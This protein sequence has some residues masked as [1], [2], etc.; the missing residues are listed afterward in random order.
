MKLAG[1][2]PIE[3]LDDERL[4]N[5]ERHV[6]AGAA[7]RLAR[8][9]PP[10][11]SLALAATVMFATGVAGVV[12][13]RLHGAPAI[14]TAPVASDPATFAVAIDGARPRVDIGDA[15]IAGEPGAVFQVTR[16]AGGVLIAMTRGKLELEVQKRGGRPPLVVRAGDT[17]VEVVGTQFSVDYDGASAVDVRVREGKVKVTRAHE[18]AFVTAGGAWSST[19]GLVAVA[20]T[21]PQAVPPAVPVAAAPP[22]APPVRIADRRAPPAPSSVIAKPPTAAPARTVARTVAPPAHEVTAPRGVAIADDP[23]VELKVAIRQQPLAFDPKLDGTRDAAA[24]IAKLKKIA[25][26]PTTL[27]A[28]ASAALYRIAVLLYK[29]LHQ[30]AEALRT[31]D[32]YRRRFARGIE[33]PA[34]AW[35]R[36]RIACGHEIDDACRQAAYSYQQVGPGGAAADVA[37]RIT[38][39]PSR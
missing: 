2:I 36:L 4:T 13:W 24:E 9:Q 33:L 8:A 20:M 22:P 15:T 14:T 32:I 25:Y 30:D 17:D 10:R 18:T 37:V 12:G 26:S 19:T 28:D 27:G 31:I 34:A 29:P 6:V 21:P 35:L 7:D 11:R 38:N 39:A 16:P 23:Y 1:R 3:P 5:I